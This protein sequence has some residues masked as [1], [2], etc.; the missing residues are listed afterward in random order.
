ML[1]AY[2]IDI[3][4]TVVQKV[5]TLDIDAVKQLTGVEFPVADVYMYPGAIKHVK[6]RHPGVME[7][8]GHLIP[9]MISNPDYIGCNPKIPDS[10]ELIKVVSEHI[11]LS[12]QLDPSSYVFVSSFYR[13]DNG[14]AKVHRRLASGRIV[15]YRPVD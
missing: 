4:S 1:S 11:L 6:R 12:I 13:L 9:G 15:L 3:D 2:S 7:T 14:I 8:Y 5:G 10:V